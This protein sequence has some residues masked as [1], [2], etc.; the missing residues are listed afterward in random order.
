MPIIFENDN[1]IIVYTHKKIIPYARYNQYIFLA[2]SI[3]WISSIIG[4]QQG[5]VIHIDNLKKRSEVPAQGTGRSTVSTINQQS[6]DQ[7]VRQVS[8]TLRDAEEE[9]RSNT[10]FTRDEISYCEGVPDREP[11]GS[12]V[13]ARTTVQTVLSTPRDNQED[14]RMRTELCNIH[15]DRVFRIEELSSDISDLDLDRPRA[16][17]HSEVI[18]AT[19]QFIWKSQK[20][21]K[22]V[23]NCVDPLSWMRSGTVI[24]KPLSTGQKRYLQCIPKDTID[25]FLEYRKYDLRPYAP[26][27]T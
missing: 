21:R 12:L 23:K 18:Q 13:T 5:L 26:L 20:E 7:S 24:V 19:E 14:S 11:L 17:S 22:A 10:N 3:W 8:T 27:S 15:P 2:Q 6:I 1:D 25:A 4:L 9:S 16:D